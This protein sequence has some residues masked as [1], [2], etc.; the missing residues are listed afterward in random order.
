MTSTQFF[1]FRQQKGSFCDMACTPID[2]DTDK[3]GTC[4]KETYD[5]R[6]R[7]VE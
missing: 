6:L 7:Q 5:V 3:R 1:S 2:E 4:Q